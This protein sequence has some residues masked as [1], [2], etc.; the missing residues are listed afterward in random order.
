MLAYWFTGYYMYVIV[1]LVFVGC[2][3]LV[4]FG[5]LLLIICYAVCFCACFVS[6]VIVVCFLCGAFGLMI[7]FTAVSCA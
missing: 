1:C 6:C 2:F 5:L 3:G 7:V 4:L